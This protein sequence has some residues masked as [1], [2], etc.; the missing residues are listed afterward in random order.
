MYYYQGGGLSSKNKTP[1]AE[2]EHQG[3]LRS[4]S[5]YSSFIQVQTADSY[6]NFLLHDQIVQQILETVTTAAQ[7]SCSFK[8]KASC[9]RAH[10]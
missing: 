1:A 3:G 7:G 6:T 2:S 10:F 8:M 9:C 4:A 5:N